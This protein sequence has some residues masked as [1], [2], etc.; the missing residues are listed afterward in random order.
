MVVGRR[1]LIRQTSGD[2]VELSHR[3]F[4]RAD[5]RIA[6]IAGLAGRCVEMVSVVVVEAP[7][8][9]RVVSDVAF[10]KVYFDADGFVDVSKRDLMI[11]LML[12]SCADRRPPAAARDRKS[13]TGFAHRARGRLDREFRWRPDRAVLNEVMIRF[14]LPLSDRLAPEALTAEGAGRS[15]VDM[16]PTVH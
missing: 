5:D 7:D 14:D 10:T 4:D 1:Y 6:P 9:K 2:L 12:E 11:R 3:D 16:K 8:H 15:G 13:L